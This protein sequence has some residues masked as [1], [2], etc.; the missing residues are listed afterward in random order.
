MPNAAEPKRGWADE[1]QPVA[2]YGAVFQRRCSMSAIRR[3]GTGGT[4]AC[5]AGAGHRGAAGSCP[6]AGPRYLVD[7]GQSLSPLNFGSERKVVKADAQPVSVE[8]R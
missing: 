2:P 3:S 8:V 5:V 6:R 4:R 7:T 1:L